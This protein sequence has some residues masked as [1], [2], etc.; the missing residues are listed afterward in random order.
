MLRRLI[1][2]GIALAS[3][4]SPCES[5]SLNQDQLPLA[6]RMVDSI[7]LCRFDGALRLADSLSWADTTDPLGPFFS[8]CVRALRDVDRNSSADSIAVW[9]SYRATLQRIES[10][11]NN[12]DGIASL[13]GLAKAVYAAHCINGQRYSSGVQAGLQSLKILKAV[14]ESYPEEY[15]ADFILGTYECGKA[16]LRQRLWWVLFWYPGST[17]QGIGML[18]KCSEK[19]VLSARAADLALVEIY[20]KEKDFERAKAYIDKLSAAYPGSRFVLWSKAKFFEASRD[21]EKSLALYTQL[22]SAYAHIPEAWRNRLTTRLERAKA[23]RDLGK[24]SESAALAGSILV[25]CKDRPDAETKD[26][27]K[28]TRDLLKEVE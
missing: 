15:E 17:R 2:V 13:E 24:K 19:A 23:L 27:C 11:R 20:T 8:L 12:R 1:F 18:T 4:I 5:L 25:E 28:Q 6:R 16:E 10:T 21:R 3:F 14:K 9:K 26:L 22:E 7:L